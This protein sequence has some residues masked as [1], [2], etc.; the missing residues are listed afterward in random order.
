MS[1]CGSSDVAEK[2]V[3]LKGSWRIKSG[4]EKRR[5][6]MKPCVRGEEGT[7]VRCFELNGRE[8]VYTFNIDLKAQ[9]GL[10]L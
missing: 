9:P 4:A 3:W 1:A 6:S 5:W 2:K 7:Q 10:Y 8:N